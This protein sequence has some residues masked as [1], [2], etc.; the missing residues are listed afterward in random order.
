MGKKGILDYF[1]NMKEKEKQLLANIKTKLPE[2][3][4]LLEKISSHWSYED[5]IYRLQEI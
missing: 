5:F 2:L 4:T 1:T 3:E